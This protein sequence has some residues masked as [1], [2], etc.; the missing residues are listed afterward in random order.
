MYFFIFEYVEFRHNVGTSK[1]YLQELSKIWENK[2][3][4]SFINHRSGPTPGFT[5][6]TLLYRV[7][8][9]KEPGQLEVNSLGMVDS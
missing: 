1:Y 3:F 8:P 9:K 2:V 5:R 7:P 6:S 4:H